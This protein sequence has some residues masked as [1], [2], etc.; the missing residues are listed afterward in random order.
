M[1]TNAQI[2]GGC[3]AHSTLVWEHTNLV[4]LLPSLF[5][6]E[7]GVGL[8]QSRHRVQWLTDKRQWAGRLTGLPGWTLGAPHRVFDVSCR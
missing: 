7:A 3:T 1:L 4:G 6:W 2:L 8:I 5:S